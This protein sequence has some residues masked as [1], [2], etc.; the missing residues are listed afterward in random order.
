MPAVSKAQ[1]R[2]L[3]MKFGPA[4][5]HRHHFDNS[6]KGEPQHVTEHPHA[7]KGMGRKK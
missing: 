4:W 2:Y 5:L 3:A 1:Q 6:T 7:R